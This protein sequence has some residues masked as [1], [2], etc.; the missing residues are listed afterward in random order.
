M[1]E[2]ETDMALQEKTEPLAVTVAEARRLL[3]IGTTS[4]YALIKRDLLTTCRAADLDRTLITYASV[5][6][7]LVP[8]APENATLPPPRRRRGRPPGRRSASQRRA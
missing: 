1:T 4:I 5:K 6:A 2:T 3:G 8:N 7:L